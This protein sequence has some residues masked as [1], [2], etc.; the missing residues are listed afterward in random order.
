MGL[1]ATMRQAAEKRGLKVHPLLLLVGLIATPMV[2]LLAGGSLLICVVMPRFG[3]GNINTPLPPDHPLARISSSSVPV[4]YVR[5]AS[6]ITDPYSLEKAKWV[7]ASPLNKAEDMDAVLDSMNG[8]RDASLRPAVDKLTAARQRGQE[9]VKNYKQAAGLADEALKDVQERAA[10]GEYVSETEA[11]EI[12]GFRADGTAITDTVRRRSDSGFATVMAFSVLRLAVGSDE[13][14]VARVRDE[15]ERSRLQAW[16]DL[17]PKFSEIY[18]QRPARADLA[19]P[20]IATGD[21]IWP[22]SLAIVNTA[23]KLL[24]EVT[25]AV[26]LVYF[27]DAPHV[28]SR[29]VLFLRQWPAEQPVYLRSNAV[30]D[31]IGDRIRANARMAGPTVTDKN[32]T[33]RPWD[34]ELGPKDGPLRGLGG[35]VEARVTVWAAEAHQSEHVVKYPDVLLA[36]ARFELG[37]LNRVT[38][39]EIVEELQK[40]NNAVDPK[41]VGPK[42]AKGQPKPAAKPR[43]KTVTVVPPEFKNLGPSSW[44]LRAGPRVAELVRGTALE[45][46]AKALLA[47]PIEIIRQRRQKHF[48]CLTQ[49]SAAKRQWSGTWAFE[50]ALFYVDRN[51]V[52]KR[53]VGSKGSL[54]LTFEATPAPAGPY[55]K[56]PAADSAPLITAR[57]FDPER[58]DAYGSLIGVITN[59]E[60]GHLVLRMQSLPESPGSAAWKLKQAGAAAQAKLKPPGL[61]A[62]KYVDLTIELTADDDGLKGFVRPT[63]QNRY[64]DYQFEVVLKSDAK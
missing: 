50:S 28:T 45:P 19:A 39:R 11:R 38:E 31:I 47:D 49:A 46:E 63:V 53:H 15:L 5:L 13:G 7:D 23:G 62:Y 61:Q 21:P 22:N 14:T 48:D 32:K 6:L 58:Q 1:I 36:G 33:W 42:G 2:V 18:G 4:D 40:G 29:Q 37:A 8:T 51:P 55:G 20:R 10:A 27:T 25:V 24:T 52:L 57:M 34:A 9:I 54:A 12:V 64:K 17:V 16:G 26:E 60:A 30:N 44:I 43:P 56:Q 41:A 3:T 59:H 35:V